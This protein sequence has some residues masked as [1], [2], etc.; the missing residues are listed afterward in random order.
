[1]TMRSTQQIGITLP[2]EIA[3]MV[4]SKVRRG[5]YASHSDVIRAGLRAVIK[6]DGAA[7]TWLRDAV[8]ARAT[9]ADLDPS[10]APPA[11]SLS[12]GKM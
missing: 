7:E 9:A 11:L 2:I 1:M 4:N 12:G 5:D 8:V 6:R 3:K 10:T